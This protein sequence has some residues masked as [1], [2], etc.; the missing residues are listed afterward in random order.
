MKYNYF[1]IVK[2]CSIFLKC[3]EEDY[4]YCD[5]DCLSKLIRNECRWNAPHVAAVGVAVSAHPPREF[6]VVAG[7]GWRED[8]D[9][10]TPG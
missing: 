4:E 10:S 3:K 7:S 5:D 2:N 6:G 8:C 9:A 1:C